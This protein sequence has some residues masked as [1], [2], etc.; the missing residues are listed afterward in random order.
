MAGG[1]CGS[2]NLM[3]KPIG[4]AT[5]YDIGQT[6]LRRRNYLQDLVRKIAEASQQA[7]MWINFDK[8]ERDIGK[9][10]WHVELRT[11]EQ[12][13]FASY[14]AINEPLQSAQMF[15]AKHVSWFRNFRAL[16]NWVA[17]PGHAGENLRLMLIGRSVLGGMRRLARVAS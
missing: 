8:F 16:V 13:G 14:E 7:G 2:L 6:F 1:I 17:M 5:K 10:D 3:A 9:Y 11:L 12:E 4:S 15:Q